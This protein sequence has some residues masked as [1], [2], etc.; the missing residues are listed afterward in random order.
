[1]AR[2][3]PRKNLRSSLP[4]SPKEKNIEEKSSW[5]QRIDE[6]H[7]FKAQNGH[8]NVS[9]YDEQNKSLGQWVNHQRALYKKNAMSSNCIQQLNSI[10]F[11]YDLHEHSWNEK[12]DHLCALKAQNGH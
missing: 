12:F 4:I 9:K 2:L 3:S 11:I 7:A 6:L 10:G 1:M 8:C 5:E